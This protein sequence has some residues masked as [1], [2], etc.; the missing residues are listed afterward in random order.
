MENINAADLYKQRPP[1]FGHGLL[2]YFAMDPKS[3]CLNHG[4]FGSSPYAALKHTYDLALKGE[5]NPYKFV[6]NDYKPYISDIRGKLAK[7]VNAQRDEIVL[8][9]NTSTGINTVLRNFAWEKGDIIIRFNTTF[10]TVYKAIDNLG[11][12]SP[13]PT[14]SE[15]ELSFPTTNQQIIDLFRKHLKSLP[16]HP[17]QKRVAVIDSI[18]ANPGVLMPWQELVKICKEEGVWSVIDA[19]H[20][21]GQEQNINLTKAAPDFWVSD[22]HKWLYAKRGVAMLY[23]PE[24]NRPIIKTSFPT[25]HLYKPVAERSVEDFVDQWIWN[26]TPDWS[27]IL[28]I[29]AALDFRK[30]IGGEAKISEYCHNLALE[31]GRRMAEIFGT[32]VIDPNGELTVNMVNVELPFPDTIPFSPQI[33]ASFMTKMFDERNAQSAPYY[34]NGRWWV[35]CCAQVYNEL[36]DF[37]KLAKHWIEVCDEVKRE[38]DSRK[39]KL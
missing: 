31:G 24:R 6:Q 16:K 28:S 1:A 13:L 5:S 14:I 12:I 27:P 3:I 2:K 23:I 9:N 17:N 35:R 39:V 37:E 21:I 33:N 34:H 8:N 18:V 29:G 36:E 15:I 7:L 25:S 20:S 30:W 22:C 32:R 10:I 11:D 38:E 19:A 26:G 4:A